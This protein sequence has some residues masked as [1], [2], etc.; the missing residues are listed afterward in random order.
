MIIG[1]TGLL[2]AG[3]TAYAV[4]RVV[5]LAQKRHA[6][7][8]SNIRIDPPAGVDFVQLPTGSD[9]FD[10]DALYALR[11]RARADHRNVLLLLDEVGL[12]L[13]ARFWASFPVPLMSF[14]TNSRKLKVDVWWVSQDDAD[15]EVSLRRRTQLVFKVSRFPG[16]SWDREEDR[17]PWLL[18]ITR[19]RSGQVGKKDKLLGRSLVRW[20]REWESWYDTD[21]LV[22]PPARLEASRRRDRSSR[23]R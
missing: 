20:R 4:S 13:P 16:Q 8:A 19:W 18:Y 21:E 10:L 22:E 11:A 23:A 7:L 5:A 14:F 15:V 2:G 9:G 1:V 12:L 17:R 6:V 3:K